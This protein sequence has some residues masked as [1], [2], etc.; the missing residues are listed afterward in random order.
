MAVDDVYIEVQR[1]HW[2]SLRKH[3]EH[4]PYFREQQRGF[5]DGRSSGEPS[6][7]RKILHELRPQEL[8]QP[9]QPSQESGSQLPLQPSQK[10]ISQIPLQPSQELGLQL[11]SGSSNTSKSKRAPAK[12]PPTR[13]PQEPH[14]NAV[15]DWFLRH[16]PMAT[17]WR[18]KQTELLLNTVEQYEQAIQAITA[19]TNVMVEKETSR[20]IGHSEHELVN[21]AERFALLTKDSLTNAK[22]QRSFAMFQA[23]VLLSYCQVLRKRGVSYETV[24]R[25]MHHVTDREW[26][27]RRLLEGALCTNGLI[28]ALVSSGWTIYRATELF[29]LSGFLK[30]PAYEAELTS[31]LDALSVSRLTRIHNDENP[32]SILEHLQTDEFVKHDYSDCLRP[33]YTIPG[34]I[35]TLLGA[36]SQT[37][38]RI[39]VDE[40]SSALGYNSVCVPK[41]V[42]S[43]YKVHAATRSTQVTPSN[44]DFEVLLPSSF[45]SNDRPLNSASSV[46]L[47]VEENVQSM[48]KN[49]ANWRNTVMNP[50]N[51]HDYSHNH[52]PSSTYALCPSVTYVKDTSCSTVFLQ[53]LLSSLGSSQIRKDMLCRGLFPQKRWNDLGNVR[54]FTLHEAGFREQ[55][56]RLF[57]SQIELEQAIKSCLRL[58]LIATGVLA[59]GCLA[60]SLSDQ[61]RFRISQSFKREELSLLGLMFMA[62]IYP[63]DQVLEPSFQH[64]GKLF[65]PYLEHT[66][67]Y[68]LREPRPTLPAHARDSLL[69]ASLAVCKVVGTS[70]AKDVISVVAKIQD[71]GIP[72]H[73]QMAIANQQSILL[74]FEGNHDRSDV[75]IQ[76]VLSRMA[77]NSTDIRSHCAYG[78]LLL[79]RTENAIFRKDFNEAVLYLETWEV[80]SSDPSGLELQVVRMKNTAIGRVSRYEGRFEHA[81]FC[82]ESCLETIPYDASRYHV[83]HHLAD[84]YC[85]MGFSEEAE[86]LV[87]DEVKQ[88]RG[89]GKQRSRN[90]RR[91]AL[92]L[93]EA[94]IEQRTLEA[95]RTT[96]QELLDAFDGII[97]HD[98]VD[99]LGHVRSMIGLARV[100][101]YESRWSEARQ[102][103][104]RALG[105][106]RKYKTFSEK[107]FYIGVIHLF[108]SVVH[109]ELRQYSE[110]QKA[111]ALANDILS[112]EVARHFMPGMGSYFLQALKAIANSQT[113][114]NILQKMH[115]S[116][117]NR[118]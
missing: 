106:T 67:Q 9:S 79:S 85:E 65:L 91:L 4:C 62:H 1:S 39:S 30:I 61:S 118:I 58:G 104:E 5:W 49:S 96:L 90:F 42:E 29:F 13:P 83:M 22:L 73:L 56:A 92:S 77:T 110:A 68:T 57:S 18:K 111:F 7:K 75:L 50:R 89:R 10:Y 11:P 66:W 40:I 86:K 112:E 2:D 99:Q 3:C 44:P 45:Q 43:I 34:L 35:A 23:L 108:L 69:E 28:V 33:E 20:A 59:D 95:A 76:D 109:L 72:N 26:D 8:S 80:K 14:R 103:L 78:R 115:E 17:G 55:V 48:T 88:L 46:Y 47:P 93:A 102:S 98:V 101:W 53:A 94:F 74:R 84:V 6:N 116:E 60:Y 71:T 54:E 38:N 100:C 105:L 32:R 82:L 64:L 41:S 37:A 51:D 81:R 19:R 63:R 87:F 113:N 16:A 15:A 31:F 27:R 12:G 117:I 24:D 36:C 52:Q 25:I 70:R 114:E 97:S 107:N 21:L